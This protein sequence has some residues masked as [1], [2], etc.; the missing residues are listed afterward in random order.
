MHVRA[1][2][3]SR[4]RAG[5]NLESQAV[6]AWVTKQSVTISSKTCDK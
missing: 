1:D 3:G 5:M 2:M 4:E 6:S